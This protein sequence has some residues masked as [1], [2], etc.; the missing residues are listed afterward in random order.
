[1]L[2]TRVSL[3]AIDEA[4]CI[5]EWG[6]NFSSGL[7]EARRVRQAVR[8]RTCF[9][10]DSTADPTEKV[11]DD[12]RRAFDIAPECVTCT[13]FYRENLT[14][15]TTSVGG[16]ETGYAASR[17]AAQSRSRADDRLRH[18][19]AHRGRSFPVSRR[20][21]LLRSRLSRRHEGRRPG[22]GAGLVFGI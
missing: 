8:C 15:L 20:Q 17:S 13:G 11:R 10:T 7:F 9:G 1:M 5:S 22:V 19:A 6:H 16:G 21:G 18:A 4:H 12:I 14:L 2:R 3:F